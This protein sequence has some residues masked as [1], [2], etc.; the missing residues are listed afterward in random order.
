MRADICPHRD[1]SVLDSI[2]I[3]GLHGKASRAVQPRLGGRWDRCGFHEVRGASI[4]AGRGQRTSER[5]QISA[6]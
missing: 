1:L 4:G 3:G 2:A 5:L 6:L